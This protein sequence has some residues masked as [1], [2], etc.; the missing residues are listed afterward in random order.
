MCALCEVVAIVQLLIV[1]HGIE[2]LI[3]QHGL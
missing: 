3:K 2:L 1:Q